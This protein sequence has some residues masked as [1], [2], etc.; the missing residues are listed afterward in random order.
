METHINLIRVVIHKNKEQ[1]RVTLVAI[2]KGASI[3]ESG[4]YSTNTTS[5]ALTRAL[6]K[7]FEGNPQL[8]QDGWIV[9]VSK[10]GL[11]LS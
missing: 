7:L 11:P 3:I 8:S 1:F 6:E 4:S 5:D 2:F 10:S 9:F